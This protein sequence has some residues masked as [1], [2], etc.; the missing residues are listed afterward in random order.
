MKL[1]LKIV[2]FAAIGMFTLATLWV[3]MV[4]YTLWL[5]DRL[6]GAR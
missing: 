1:Y 6:G 2:G 5:S 3:S 4:H